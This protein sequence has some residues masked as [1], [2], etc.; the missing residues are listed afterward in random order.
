MKHNSFSQQ[1]SL[2]A[3]EE[4]KLN[5]KAQSIFWLFSM[6]FYVCYSKKQQSSLSSSRLSNHN[7][8]LYSP[9]CVTRAQAAQWRPLVTVAPT[10]C[11]SRLHRTQ[12]PIPSL[13]A[14]ISILKRLWKHWKVK[15]FFSG[16]ASR[17]VR[18]IDVCEH[19]GAPSD[20]RLL[21]L[22]NNRLDCV[23]VL[24][25]T[26]VTSFGR[27]IKGQALFVVA[28]TLMKHKQTLVEI[29]KL[30]QCVWSPE[31]QQLGSCAKT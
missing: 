28:I 20:H 30:F 12:K 17:W 24:L 7:E 25:K 2:R 22:D 10:I 15:V 23:R 29:G 9:S 5:S 18:R 4:Y 3:I 19:C 21:V 11:R 13:N 8:Q 16:K 31:L 1:Q 14:R 6:G 27:N 26:F